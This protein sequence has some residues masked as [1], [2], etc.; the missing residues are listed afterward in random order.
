MKTFIQAISYYL[1]E[2][3]VT[4]EQIV[5]EFPTWTVEK[6]NIKIGIKERH[7]TADDETAA[8]IAVRSAEKLF[9]EYAIEKNTI[10]YL[11]FCTQNPD[12]ILPTT[13]C[14]IQDRLGLETTIGAV[15]INLGCSGWI[16]GLSVAKGMI[17]GGMATRVL[18]LTAETYSKHMHPKD[19]SN[20][21]IF[22]DGAAA[23][24]IGTDGLAGIGNF[25]F[26]TDGQG[27]ENL[28]V[29]TGGARHRKPLNDLQ[30]DDFGNPRSSD[31]L[32]MNGTE[33]LNYTLD[34]IPSLVSELL[35]KND[36]EIDD[37][38]LHVY[39]QANKY[40][41]NLQRRKLRIP[42]GK[43]YCFYE[44]VGNTVSSTIPIAIKEAIN[45]GTIRKGYKVMSVAQGLGYSWGGILLQF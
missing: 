14:I 29:K 7:I 39:H 4:N 19:K 42:E 33:I 30:F 41:A 17:M 32:Y 28:I 34:R 36:L 26:G 16:Y 38:D 35:K 24:L 23:T 5:Q 6:I 2:K 25:C 12:Y 15:D 11:I 31:Y 1:P 13:A 9:A 44:N 37:I 10:D 45:D 21:T 22:A 8:D 18:L 27:A 20:R 40:L 43:Y 3:V